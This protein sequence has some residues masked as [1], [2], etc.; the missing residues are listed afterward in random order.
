MSDRDDELPREE[1]LDELKKRYE[2]GEDS[3]RELF[4]QI[5]HIAIYLTYDLI[6]KLRFYEKETVKLSDKEIDRR[7]PHLSELL[8]R[9]RSAYDSFADVDI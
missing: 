8:D 4:L 3:P 7:I 1:D 2:A 5:S 9:L 6:D